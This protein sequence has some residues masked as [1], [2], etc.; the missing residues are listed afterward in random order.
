MDA[1]RVAPK[2]YVGSY[3]EDEAKLA[4]AGFTHVVR[5]A[6]ECRLVEFPMDDAPLTVTDAFNANAAAS[7]VQRALATGGRV[8]VTCFMGVNRSA[9]VAA[10][11]MIRYYGLRP[12]EAIAQ[13]RA[14]R[15]PELTAVGVLSNQTFVD[16]LLSTPRMRLVR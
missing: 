14:L 2:L 8:L 7:S 10:L 1:D 15:R 13:V 4:R 12:A 9:F 6:K 11:A 16:A 3:Q 5:V